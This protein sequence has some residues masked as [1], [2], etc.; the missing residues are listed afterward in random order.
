MGGPDKD[1][2]S[3]NRFVK[4]YKTLI[5]KA[6][7]LAAICDANV[8]VFINHDRGSFVYNS[9]G[10]GSWPPPDGAL[11]SMADTAGRFMLTNLQE[12]HYPDVARKSLTEKMK[13]PGSPGVRFKRLTHYFAARRRVL[14]SLDDVYRGITR[15]GLDDNITPKGDL[16]ESSAEHDLVLTPIQT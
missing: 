14:S 2:N 8:Y 6:N 11:V 10:D 3:R 7:Q 15:I 5:A 9:V 16:M 1:R 12:A 13:S 4:R